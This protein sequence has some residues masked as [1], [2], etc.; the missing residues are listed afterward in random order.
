MI[1]I[2][3]DRQF[4]EDQ[5][6]ERKMVMTTV[7][8]VFTKKQERSRKREMEQEERKSKS[9][10]SP[11]VAST[12]KESTSKPKDLTFLETDESSNESHDYSEGEEEYKMSKCQ[13][14]KLFD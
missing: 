14:E 6:G 13:I 9:Q 2:E 5:R 3:E 11:V 4:L 7:D 12:S 10:S 1:K 8:K